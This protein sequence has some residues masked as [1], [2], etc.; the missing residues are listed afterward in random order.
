MAAIAQEFQILV[1]PYSPGTRLP[2]TTIDKAFDTLFEKLVAL[3]AG[4]SQPSVVGAR[5]EHGYV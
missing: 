2:E 1:S 3:L 5:Q 4:W